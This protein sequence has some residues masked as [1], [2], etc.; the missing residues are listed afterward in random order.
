MNAKRLSIPFVVAV[1]LIYG[2][3]G[4]LNAGSTPARAWDAAATAAAPAAALEWKRVSGSPGSKHLFAIHFV[5][6]TLAWAGGEEGTLLRYDGSSWEA[7][8]SPTNYGL[9][10]LAMLGPDQG[11]ATSLG[12]MLYFTNGVWALWPQQLPFSHSNMFAIDMADFAHGW[13]VGRNGSILGFDGEKWAISASPTTIQLQSVVALSRTLAFAVGGGGTILAYR[14]EAWQSEASP[15][16]NGLKALAM[17]GPDEG[18][19]VGDDGMIVHYDGANWTVESSPVQD[20]LRAVLIAASG[21]AWAVGQ[22]GVIVHY[23]GS[24]WRSEASPSPYTLYGLG[25]SPGGQVWA[26]GFAG[27]I[28]QY[29]AGQWLDA[30]RL[31]P[32]TLRD[33]T[34]DGSTGWAVGDGGAIVRHAGGNWNVISSPTSATLYALSQ[35]EPGSLWAAGERGTLLHNDGTGWAASTSPTNFAL[36]E[37]A[38]SAPNQGWAVG[39]EQHATSS[40]GVILHYDGTSWQVASLSPQQT[41][42]ALAFASPGDGWAVGNGGQIWRYDGSAWSAYDSP[43]GQPLWSVAVA[44]PSEAWAVGAFGT[45]LRYDGHTWQ[46][47]ASPTSH[48]LHKIILSGPGEAWAFGDSGTLLHYDKLGWRQVPSPTTYRLMGG[49]SDDNGGLWAV[50]VGGTLLHLPAGSGLELSVSPG[51]AFITPGATAHITPTISGLGGLSE[52]VTLSVPG[53]PDG[54]SANWST[55]VVTPPAQPGLSLTAATTMPAGTWSLVMSANSGTLTRT[56]CF[57]LSVL[58]GEWLPGSSLPTERRLHAVS[59][60]GQGTSWAVGD[61]GMIWRY[62]ETN[63]QGQAPHTS[64]DLY[65]VAAFSPSLAWAAGAGG[66]LLR[67]DGNDWLQASSPTTQS[68]FALVLTAANAGWAVGGEGTLLRYDGN[69]WQIAPSP[70]HDWLYD[71]AIASDGSGWAVGWGG[72]IWRYDGTSWQVADSPASTWLRGVTCVGPEEAW[73]VGSEGTIAHYAN[74]HWRLVPAPSVARLFDVHFDGPDDGWAVGGDGTV[75]RYDTSGWHALPSPFAPELRALGRIGSNYALAVG[76]QGSLACYRDRQA[77]TLLLPGCGGRTVSQTWQMSTRL[78][79]PVVNQN[80]WA[81]PEVDLF[82]VQTIGGALSRDPAIVQQMAEAGIQW[83]R[84]SLSWKLI[85]PANTSPERFY[86]SVYDDWLELL[87][88][89]GIHPLLTL[90]SNPSWA[91][92]LPAWYINQSDGAEQQAFV[93]AA[94]ARYSQAPYRVSHWEIYNEPD[95]ASL[96]WAEQ[97]WGWWGDNATGYVDQLA[98]LYPVIKAVDPSAQVLM[99]GLAYDYFTDAGGPFVQSFITDV[100]EAGGGAYFDQM[101]FHYYGSDLNGRFE[102]FEELLA[103]HGL[104][105]PLVCTEVSWGQATPELE[106]DGERY[107]R[108]VPQVMLRGLAHHLPI[109]NW[110]ALGDMGAWQPGL[111]AAD[112]TRR[113]AYRAYR[114]LTSLLRTA[115]YERPLSSEEIGGAPLEGYVLSWQGGSRRMDVL[116]TTDDTTLE[117]RVTAAQLEIVDKYGQAH[118]IQDAD[119]GQSDGLTTFQVGPSP[120]YVRY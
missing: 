115:R 62:D 47:V 17:S 1:G 97:G 19:A 84:L 88:T 36:R 27:T 72:A 2:L 11:W 30:T 34:W 10:G 33:V 107:A 26:V 117:R 87:S 80:A 93:A 63:W 112:Q 55:T 70:G 67:F 25:Q 23:D 4:L 21:E 32:A 14:G 64:H 76:S 100:L 43:T 73:A 111:F 105:K 53:L 45:I 104:D 7:V 5:S 91:A 18:W 118:T 16:Q 41:L 95:N 116:W 92:T 37:L 103:S 68:L 39:G 13:A 85:E 35:A 101:N 28:L 3:I 59:Y 44:G 9:R 86:W 38:F 22:G 52:P 71:V 40:A 46:Q 77:G 109:V 50:G 20:T 106:A 74:G 58:P 48:G 31:T 94:V 110:F 120:I 98:R 82:G 90:S 24:V 114:T 60:D 8:P 65:A 81:K 66:T 78:F 89:A 96:W 51:H 83:A 102:L 54:L 56:T 12:A 15:T 42:Y 29:Q 75:L 119:D 57:S 113:P 108:Y 69:A 61:Q 99:G 79:L 6:D 49:A